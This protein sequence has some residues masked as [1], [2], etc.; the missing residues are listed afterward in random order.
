MSIKSNKL[1]KPVLNPIEKILEEGFYQKN[2]SFFESFVAQN[3][4]KCR[5]ILSI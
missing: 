5:Q 4:V 2:E 1:L 3:G